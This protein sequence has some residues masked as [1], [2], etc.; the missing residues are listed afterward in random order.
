MKWLKLL[1]APIAGL[2]LLLFGMRNDKWA[3]RA[4]QNEED[5]IQNDL[6]QA[7]VANQHAQAHDDKAHEIKAEAE[8]PKGK[9]STESIVDGWR[10]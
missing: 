4:V 8:K 3:K 6:H 1:W 7:E 9:R 5:D 2:L 10:Q